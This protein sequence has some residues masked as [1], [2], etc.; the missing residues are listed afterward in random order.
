MFLLDNEQTSKTYTVKFVYIFDVSA[1]KHL[2]QD[3]QFLQ[4]FRLLLA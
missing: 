3:D 1:V 2:M 4:I